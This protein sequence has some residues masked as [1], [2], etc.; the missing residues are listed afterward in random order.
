MDFVKKP[1]VVLSIASVVISSGTLFYT[2]QRLTALTDALDKVITNVDAI[3][4]TIG[5]LRPKEIM[6]NKEILTSVNENLRKLD[7]FVYNF[8][9]EMDTFRDGQLYDNENIEDVV[10]S[11]AKSLVEL[12]STSTS[13]LE[14]TNVEVSEPVPVKR[15]GVRTAVATTTPT[16]KVQFRN[17]DREDDEDEVQSKIAKMRQRKTR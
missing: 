10:N 17:E 2:N 13:C 14:L 15:R 3:G 9:Q 16:R 7:K 8:K 12:G 6:E 11:L 1:E 4:K 5:D